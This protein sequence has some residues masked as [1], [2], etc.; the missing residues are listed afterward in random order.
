MNWN[1]EAR[2]IVLSGVPGSGKTTLCQEI[3]RRLSDQGV[4]VAGIISPP[5][6]ENGIKTRILVRDLRTGRQTQL[7]EIEATPGSLTEKRWRFSSEGWEHGR[8]GLARALP[9]DV[10]IIDEIGPIEI[11]LSE[12]WVYA[13]EL[14]KEVEYRKALVTVRPEL[15]DHFCKWTDGAV[16]VML[17]AAPES[18]MSAMVC[19]CR[20]IDPLLRNRKS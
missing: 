10:L 16:P 2:I 5:V 3:Y 9:C 19:M 14:L 15:L 13:L 7:A 20:F 6:F 17:T 4:D 18:R 8:T 1:G 12:G 11:L